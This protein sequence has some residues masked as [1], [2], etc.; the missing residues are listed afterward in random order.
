MDIDHSDDFIWSMVDIRRFLSG[1]YV[2]SFNTVTSSV[3]IGVLTCN[4]SYTTLSLP[5]G[6]LSKCLSQTS[7][8]LSS[9][10]SICT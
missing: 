2:I 3:C 8:A 4:S 5:S 10:R 1:I 7:L 6:L 9:F